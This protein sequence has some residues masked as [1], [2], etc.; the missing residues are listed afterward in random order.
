MGKI[1]SRIH[2]TVFTTTIISVEEIEK[3]YLLGG[4]NIVVDNAAVFFKKVEDKITQNDIKKILDEMKNDSRESF[5]PTLLKETM[6]II[7][8]TSVKHKISQG[9]AID[10]IVALYKNNCDATTGEKQ[11]IKK[12]IEPKKEKFNLIRIG[13]KILFALYVKYPDFMSRNELLCLLAEMGL[14]DKEEITQKSFWKELNK[15]SNNGYIHKSGIGNYI[16]YLLT[17]SGITYLLK[18]AVVDKEARIAG[19]ILSLKGDIEKGKAFGYEKILYELLLEKEKR[20]RQSEI[21]IRSGVSNISRVVRDL[22]NKKYI[23]IKI[24]QIEINVY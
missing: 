7:N 14:A 6:N 12:V 9:G 11:I 23:Y 21:A 22:C 20:L 2:T 19:M 18:K 1:K 16:K 13:D 15:Y 24:K 10:I 5:A 17:D 3:R 8:R 4:N